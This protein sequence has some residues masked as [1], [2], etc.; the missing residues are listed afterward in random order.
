MPAFVTHLEST[1]D[2]SSHPSDRPQQVHENKPFLVRYDLDAVRAAT[3]RETVM[4]RPAT[5][6]R[7][8]ELLPL[9]S[10]S[11]P[12]TLGETET[13]LLDCPRLAERLGM[14]S[15]RI[16]DESRLPG[17][18]FKARGMAMAVSMAH[19]FGTKKMAVPTAGNAGGALAAYAARAGIECHVFMPRDTPVVNRL[20]AIAHGESQLVGFPVFHGN[21][22]WPGVV[23]WPPRTVPNSNVVD[24]ECEFGL[25][26]KVQNR[27]VGAAPIAAEIGFVS[28]V[29]N[30]P[31]A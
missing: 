28:V 4:K 26:A 12:V 20:E 21:A 9:P 7:F 29:P 30:Q 3:T 13:P 23:S 22:G 2:G 8:R 16:K 6:W 5:M 10:E 19:H 25:F 14:S 18:S 24:V 17:G 15:L 11:D 1:F 31:T 27:L